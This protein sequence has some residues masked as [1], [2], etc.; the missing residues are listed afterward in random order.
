[1]TDAEIDEKVLGQARLVMS[2]GRSH[3]AL[4]TCREIAST[5]DIAA[6]VGR[7]VGDVRPRGSSPGAH[8]A[9]GG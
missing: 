6:V 7:L 2:E 8:D 5:G 3:D 1:M 4:A 9:D